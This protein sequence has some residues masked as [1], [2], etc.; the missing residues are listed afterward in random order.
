MFQ[1]LPKEAK[2]TAQA[3]QNYHCN[4][5]LLK[6]CSESKEL[7]I[8]I[9]IC[10]RH[11]SNTQ[12]C[13][14]RFITYVNDSMK[15]K[16]EYCLLVDSFVNTKMHLDNMLDQYKI[17]A[18]SSSPNYNLENAKK[19][20]MNTTKSTSATITTAKHNNNNEYNEI[21][22]EQ[23]NHI[24]TISNDLKE[25]TSLSKNIN[26]MIL[27]QSEVINNVIDNNECNIEKTKLINRRVERITRRSQMK[28]YDP[29]LYVSVC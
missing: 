15:E 4:I 3:T 22:K 10:E 19:E 2:P 20:L 13:L 16:N 11:K 21:E 14:K 7:K 25:I 8:C 9:D 6:Q 18:S 17:Q 26:T 27:Q 23:I 5:L 29:V 12:L 24:N 1:D 28:S